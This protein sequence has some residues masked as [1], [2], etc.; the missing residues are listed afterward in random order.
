[1]LDARW[2]WI[3]CR[4]WRRADPLTL[5]TGAWDPERRRHLSGTVAT[6]AEEVTGSMPAL[7]KSPRAMHLVLE[8]KNNTTVD[9]WPYTFLSKGLAVNGQVLR[10]HSES[11]SVSRRARCHGGVTTHAEGW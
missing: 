6:S 5:S 7:V 11:F 1:M 2:R 3:A 8:S 10:F 9:L 4:G